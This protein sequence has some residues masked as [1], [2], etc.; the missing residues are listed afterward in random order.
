[1]VRPRH[2]SVPQAGHGDQHGALIAPFAFLGPAYDPQ[3]RAVY[4][5]IGPDDIYRTHWLLSAVFNDALASTEPLFRLIS[6]Y[7]NE[8]M[9][10]A[11]AGEYRKG[12]LLLIGTTNLDVQ[13]PVIWNTG[14]IAASE[15]AGALDLFRKVLLPSESI[16]G[17]FPPVM[18][19]VEAGG[20]HFQDMHVDGGAAAQT[21]LIPASVSA[22]TDVRAKEFV[23]QRNAYVI[24]NA[25]LDPDW[26][27]MD[28]NLLSITGRAIDTIDLLR[29]S[30]PAQ[31]SRAELRG[32]S[33][34]D[35]SRDDSIRRE[36]SSRRCPLR[37]PAMSPPP[38]YAP[39]R[40][41]SA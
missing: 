18:I 21:F 30:P 4:T 19:D 29:K 31:G 9:L 12:R 40:A 24:R 32:K 7:C 27:I 17:V 8:K 11:I 2:A 33:A 13:R 28:R 39:V 5:D 38:G 37:C 20:Q 34:L 36:P 1:M 25:R 22:L 26:A 3:L 6:R 10:A 23:R 16:P 35:R 41:S 14:A 15:R